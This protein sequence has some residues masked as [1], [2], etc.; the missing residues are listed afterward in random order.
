MT[1]YSYSRLCQRLDAKRNLSHVICNL[2]YRLQ[3]NEGAL[4]LITDN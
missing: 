3:W 4:K 1:D 2:F